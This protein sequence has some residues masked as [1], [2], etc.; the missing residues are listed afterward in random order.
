MKNNELLHLTT[1][2]NGKMQDLWSLSTS[3]LENEFCRKRA[4]NK[5]SICAY[6]FSERMANRYQNL[7]NCLKKNTSILTTRILTDDE[8]PVIESEL[9]RFEAFGDLN[10]EIQVVNYFKI[11]SAN[12]KVKCALWTKNPWF[13][14]SA[15]EK[16]GIEKP[17]NLNIIYSSYHVDIPANIEKLKKVYPFID[18]VFTVYR[19]AT[20]IKINCGARSCNR[21]RKCY[22]KTKVEYIN[23]KIK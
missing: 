18:K 11:A 3:T 21:C 7:E 12:K 8:I 1:K 10:N 5:D 9:F 2:H 17:K 15:M 13:I 23:E 14:K 6:C 4:E 16:Y 22:Y 19:D 20:D